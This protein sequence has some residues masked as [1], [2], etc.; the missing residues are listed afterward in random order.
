MRG[1]TG[2]VDT[3]IEVNL[4]SFDFGMALIIKAHNA[5]DQK[6]GAVSG[7]NHRFVHL[8]AG[9]CCSVAITSPHLRYC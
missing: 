6:R 9:S 4:S 1:A 2:G 5:P 7:V 3:Q 8:P